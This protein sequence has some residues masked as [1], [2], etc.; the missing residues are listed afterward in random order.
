MTA[1]A[2]TRAEVQSARIR[3]SAALR[4]LSLAEL[5]REVNDAGYS[6]SY[7]K[8]RRAFSDERTTE[9]ERD[10]IKGIAAVTGAP[11]DY[12]EGDDD[13]PFPDLHM[14]VYVSSDLLDL[15]K[16]PA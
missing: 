2:M 14:G 5:H 11:V 16:V 4:N 12:V 15:L 9:L 6:V 7:E 13:I 8:L 10:I 1:K 3:I